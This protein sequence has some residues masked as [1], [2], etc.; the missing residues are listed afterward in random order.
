LLD[1]PLG[2]LDLKLREAMQDE[3]K[4]LQHKLGLTFV[5]V[6]HDQHEALSMA[7]RLA[8]FNEGKI[9][10]IGT[11]QDIYDRP[12]TRFVADFV[13]SSNVLPPALTRALGGPAEWA[14]CARGGAPCRHR[15]G[16]GPVTALRYLGSG[17]RVVIDTDGHRDRRPGPR[18]PARARRRR[19]RVA[20][21]F[22]PG[23]LHLM[24]ARMRH[25]R[26]SRTTRAPGYRG[27]CP[28]YPRRTPTPPICR[29]GAPNSSFKNSG[30]KAAMTAPA[31]LPARGPADRLT[32]LFWRRPAVLLALLI[33]AASVAG[34]GL[35]WLALRAAAAVVLFDRRIFGRGERGIHPQDLCR[36]VAGAEPGHHHCAPR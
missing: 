3:L 22:D 13:G 14:S 27:L 11:P 36:A 31:I 17:T 8:V 18:R 16:D 28:K 29:R 1:E 10:Q 7:D 6:T 33:P 32:G 4:A 24:G 12:A 15:P 19:H 26:A 30:L 9:A 23:A 35:S 20:I 2:A 21:A 5:F 25:D 34:G